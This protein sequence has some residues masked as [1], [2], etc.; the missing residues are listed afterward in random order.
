MKPELAA[1]FIAAILLH[2][3]LLFGFRMEIP[4]RPLAMSD[5]PSPVDVRLVEAAPEPPAPSAAPTPMRPVPTPEPPT[6]DMST[7]PPETTP[8]QKEMLAAETPAPPHPKAAPHHSPQNHSIASAAHSSPGPASAAGRAGTTAHEAANGQLN[9][10]A[11]YLSNPRPDYPE[12]ARRQ[13]QEGVV[14]VSADVGTDGVASNAT[15]RR[16]SGFPLLDAAAIRAVRRWTFKPARA[17]GLAV[18]SRVDVPVRFS[19]TR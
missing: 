18:S 3:L 14:V 4:T 2:A 13:H 9:S 1:S 8:E 11:R 6:P 19:L 7:P 12:E 10:P 16:S 5:E 15:L 17:A